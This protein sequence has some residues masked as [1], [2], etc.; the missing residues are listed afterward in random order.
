MRILV[1]GAAGL[2]GSK[3]MELGSEQLQIFG[4]DRVKPQGFYD[5]KLYLLDITERES[6]IDAV[7]DIGPD[8]VV[9]SAAITDVDFC[10]TH[11]EIAR[12]VNVEGT[13]NIADAA[14]LAGAKMVYV[15]SDYI[16]DGKLGPY[17]E[18]DAPNPIGVYGRTKLDG[19]EEVKRSG[20]GSIIARS[21]VIF[22]H[23]ALGLENFATWAISKL[24]IGEK[25]RV[26]NDQ[27][28]NPTLADNCAQMILKLIEKNSYGTYNVVGKDY[29]S[30]YDFALKIADSFGFDKKLIVPVS[31]EELGQASRRPRMG[32]LKTDKIQVLGIRP[33]DIEESL[34]IMKMQMI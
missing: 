18:D 27:F 16:F 2:L 32:G 13:R 10:E 19:E 29:V 14:G 12:K 34:E 25:I 21:T 7:K 8:W 22:G 9:H 1:T 5:G 3:L 28:G 20:A 30:R 6:V 17:S 15:S 31:S 23:H 4:C 11:Q 33:M 24:K 26:V